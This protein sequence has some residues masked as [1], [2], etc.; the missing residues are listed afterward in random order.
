MNPDEDFGWFSQSESHVSR[1]G[2][3]LVDVELPRVSRDEGVWNTSVA[4]ATAIV[5]TQS[6][7]IPKTSQADILVALAIPWTDF[8]ATAGDH[9]KTTTYQNSLK[10][11]LAVSE[12]LLPPMPDPLDERGF[13]VVSFRAIYSIPKELLL[14]HENVVTM[15]SPYREH[16]SQAFSRFIMRVGLPST[17]NKS[18]LR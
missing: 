6:C 9:A 18:Q 14:S 4:V 8:L 11:G 2:D 10:Q 12:F 7:D 1:Q 16:L 13:H 15:Q 5:L 3:V 17:L